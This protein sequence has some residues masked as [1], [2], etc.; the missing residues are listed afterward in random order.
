MNNK[1]AR[2]AAVMAERYP[3]EPLFN[4]ALDPLERFVRRTTAGG[5]VLALATLLALVLANSAWGPALEHLWE[6]RAEFGFQPGASLTL[7][8]H[9]WINDGLMALFFLAVGLE[10]K[11][12]LL[13]GELSSWRD[14]LLPVVAAAGGMAVPAGI[15]LAFNYGLPTQSGWAIPAATDIAF[16]VGILVMLAAKAPR[17]L[18]LFLMALAIADDLGAVLIIALFYAGTPDLAALTVAGVLLGG[19]ILL[20]Q[21]GIRQPLPYWLLG[22]CLWYCLLLSG[23]HATLAG[24]LL[25]F[26]LPA[27]PVHSPLVFDDRVQSLLSRFRGHALDP[28]TPSDVLSSHDMASIAASLEQAA[29]TVQSPLQ[30]MEFS[31]HPWVTFAILP[32]FALANAGIDFGSMDIVASLREPVTQGVFFGLVVGKFV[33]VSLACFLAVRLGVGAL[34]AG[35]SWRHVLGTAWLA[36]I[37]FT[38]SLFISQLAFPEPVHLVQAKLGVLLASAAAAILGIAWLTAASRTPRDD[39]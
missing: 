27:K 35:V 15:Y 3:L 16:A 10:L 7:P 31:L 38:M 20:N 4:R 11:R 32:L 12:E 34:P 28:T 6:I 17:N 37:G 18:T 24:I 1:H 25:A 26:T 13:V 39:P 22:L 19:L 30:R 21:G 36:G 33:G 23:L 5:V 29:K 8:L 9:V 14:A 2:N